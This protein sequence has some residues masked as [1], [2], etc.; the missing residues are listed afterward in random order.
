MWALHSERDYVSRLS[1]LLRVREGEREGEK[2]R[3]RERGRMKER[4]ETEFIK[5]TEEGTICFLKFILSLSLSLFLD[6][7]ERGV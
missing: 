1:D 4:E 7:F 3:E 6:S 5:G 2:E